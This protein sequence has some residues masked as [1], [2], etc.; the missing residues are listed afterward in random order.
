MA[1]SVY[2]TF[3]KDVHVSKEAL[4]PNDNSEIIGNDFGRTPSAV[5]MQHLYGGRWAVLHE[6]IEADQDMGAGCE[7]LKH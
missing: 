7:M 4:Q 6:V 1:R 3:R 2:P 5:F